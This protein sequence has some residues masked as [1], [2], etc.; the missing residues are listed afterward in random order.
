MSTRFTT[1]RAA[2]VGAVA[3]TL[4]ALGCAPSGYYRSTSSSLDSLLTMQAKQQRRLDALEREISNTRESVQATRASSDTRL[5]E[6]N[7]RMDQL[8][9]KLEESGMKFTNLAQKFEGVKQRIAAGD[10]E[11]ATNR[12]DST[13][14]LIVDPEEAFR[15]ALSDYT[16]GRYA[17]AKDA[18]TDYLGRFPDTEVSDN[19]QYLIG[20]CL[21]NTGDFN[22]AIEAYRKVVENYPKGDKVAASL[23]KAGIA[24]A[25]IKDTAA[26][27][28]YY[29]LVIK[30]YPKSDEARIA[31][32]RLGQKTP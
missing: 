14:V 7:G 4:S 10:S 8:Q 15:A 30:K 28:Q 31:R 25:R 2:A 27:K 3:L 5:S 29:A 9:G 26:S 11:R 22:G 24:S 16:A 32:E 17:L 13:R 1:F 21:Y 18:F 20:E 6:L 19:A 12:S 23:L